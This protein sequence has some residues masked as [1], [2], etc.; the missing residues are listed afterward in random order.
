MG[1]S[2]LQALRILTLEPEHLKNRSTTSRTRVIG[3]GKGSYP[4]RSS[5]LRVQFV[6]V[7]VFSL[8][9]Q[10]Q[11]NGCNLACQLKAHHGRLDAFGERALVKLLERS[12]LHTGPS[13]SAFKQAFQI[14][15]VVLV[16]P[17]NG[18]LFFAP[19]HLPAD[20][21]IFPAVASFQPQSAVSP[22]LALAAKTMGRL[23]QGHRQNGTDW[24]QGGN[25]SELGGD[26]MFATFRQQFASCLLAQVLQ[27]VQLLIELLGPA[28]SAG[29]RIFSSHWLRWR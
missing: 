15:V 14:V 27:H 4:R 22:Q 11:R 19:P 1:T 24:A 12:G 28:P 23:N 29:F 18:R 13:G 8:L 21:V 9:P 3:D 25:L 10:S 26:G 17:A 16:Q 6:D 5:D 2:C 20:V 7:E